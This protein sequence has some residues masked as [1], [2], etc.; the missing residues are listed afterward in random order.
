MCLIRLV[1]HVGGALS[2]TVDGVAKIGLSTAAI[3]SSGTTSVTGADLELQSTGRLDI[4][5]AEEASF[6]AQNMQVSLPSRSVA[7]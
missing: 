5:V 1:V 6:R 7:C 2:T 3:E 4:S